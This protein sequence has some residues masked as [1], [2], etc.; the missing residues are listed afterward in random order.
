MPTLVIQ[1]AADTHHIEQCDSGVERRFPLGERSAEVNHAI[2]LTD[3]RELQEP[4]PIGVRIGNRALPVAAERIALHVPLAR[5][6]P[7]EDRLDLVAQLDQLVVDRRARDRGIPANRAGVQ[8]LR[9][10][11]RLPPVVPYLAEVLKAGGRRTE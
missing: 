4:I 2:A 5:A 10:E 3:L 9:V 7:E 8:Y 6:E 11:L 1:E